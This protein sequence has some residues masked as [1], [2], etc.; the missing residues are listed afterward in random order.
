MK[1]DLLCPTCSSDDI[2]KNGHTPREKQNY[3]CRECGRQ[4]VEDPLWKPKDVDTCA[5]IELLLLKRIPLAGIARVLK[6]SERWLQK[7]VN[8]YYQE[9]PRKA[10]VIPKD[11]SKLVVKMDEL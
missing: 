5:M 7:Y 11:P 8:H 2:M 6:L 3:K 10:A 9:V 1:L 4:F